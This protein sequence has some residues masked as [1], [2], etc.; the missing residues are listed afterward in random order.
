M[1]LIVTIAAL[2]ILATPAAAEV[3]A[4]ND[5]RPNPVKPFVATSIATFDYPWAIAFLPDGHML[6]TE[7][8][9]KLYLVSQT[10]GKQQVTGVPRVNYDS[11]RRKGFSTSR[12]RRTSPATT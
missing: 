9:G 11:A 2:L 3:N 8:P 7:K 4:G 12:S 6:V 1:R 10:G 5:N